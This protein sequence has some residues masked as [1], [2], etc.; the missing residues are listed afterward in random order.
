ML[1]LVHLLREHRIKRT[2]FMSLKIGLRTARL[3]RDEATEIGHSMTRDA[4]FRRMQLRRA[5]LEQAVGT[6]PHCW[7]GCATGSAL[8]ICGSCHQ[9]EEADRRHRQRV[10]TARRGSQRRSE[11]VEL[12]PELADEMDANI[13]GHRSHRQHSNDSSSEDDESFDS[14]ATVES[15]RHAWAA[16]SAA[17]TPLLP[18]DSFYSQRLRA[19]L[20]KWRTKFLAV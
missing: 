3:T 10:P 9:V 6:L 2:V 16:A 20:D 4:R 5:R 17:A 11:G 19:D 14:L 13:A 15:E 7:C 12:L 18:R 8:S 1:R